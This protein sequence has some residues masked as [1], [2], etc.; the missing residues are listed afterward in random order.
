MVGNAVFFSKKRRNK[1][2]AKGIQTEHGY[3][4]SHGEAK[5][6]FELRILERAGEV[7]NLKRQV[8]YPLRVNDQ[9][10]CSYIA[11]FVYEIKTDFGWANV[12]EDFKSPVTR[13]LAEYQIKKKLMR[14]CHNVAI[15]ETGK[16]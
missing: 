14:A 7:R 12:V 4:H 13:R 8:I 5:R 9:L 2:R 10:V 11:D 6:F 1:Y 3:F 15:H 16:K